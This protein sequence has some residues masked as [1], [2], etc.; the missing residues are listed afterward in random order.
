MNN[1]EQSKPE[2]ID[3]P[4]GLIITIAQAQMAI[5]AAMSKAEKNNWKVAI[6]ILEPNGQLVAFAKMDGTQYGSVD[7]SRAKAKT[8]ALLKRPSKFYENS[9][10][11][12]TT[13]ETLSLLSLIGDVASDGGLPLIYD[14]E[15]IG[16]IGVSGALSSQDGQVAKAGADTL[17]ALGLSLYV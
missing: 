11:D 3:T 5:S 12:G 1:Q 8:A 10:N 14:G 13:P 7:I 17:L 6:T 16:A 2:A 9:V 4:Y 15:I